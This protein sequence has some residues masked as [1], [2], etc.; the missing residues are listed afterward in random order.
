MIFFKEYYGNLFLQFWQYENDFLNEI[1]RTPDFG[2]FM[3]KE[4]LEKLREVRKS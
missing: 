1:K 2:F 4:Y 3:N